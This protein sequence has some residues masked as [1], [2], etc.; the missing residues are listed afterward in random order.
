MASGNANANNAN[1]ANANNNNKKF[2][3]IFFRVEVNDKG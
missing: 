1:N 2:F 3:K